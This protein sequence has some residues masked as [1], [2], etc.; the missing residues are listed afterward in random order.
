M[1][2]GPVPARAF[3]LADGEA[4]RFRV[5]LD[6]VEREALVV[7]W[8]GALSAWVNS[9]RH[10]SRT[11]DLGDARVFDGACDALVCVHHGARYRPDTGECVEGPCRGH[12]L[13]PLALV[14]REGQLWCTGRA[15]ANR[16]AD[17]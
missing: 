2:G 12:G 5:E 1:N 13:T 3:T 4:A 10:Q 9:C 8:N 14:E 16:A 6:G 11:L 17:V 15:P 7:R